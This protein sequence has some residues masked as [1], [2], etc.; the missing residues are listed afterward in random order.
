MA[1]GENLMLTAQIQI[2]GDYVDSFVYSGVL[3]LLDTQMKLTTYNWK[4]ILNLA[5][6]NHEY[7]D[8]IINIFERKK[9]NKKNKRP[10]EI[11]VVT[12]KELATLNSYSTDFDFWLTD[13][14]I[15]RNT[16]FVSGNEGVISQGAEWRRGNNKPEFEFKKTRNSVFSEPV[17]DM[18]IGVYSSL[19]PNVDFARL[20]VSCGDNGAYQIYTKGEKGNVHNPNDTYSLSSEHWIGCDLN[21]NV[22]LAVLKNFSH[23]QVFRF[24]E[25]IENEKSNEKDELICHSEEEISKILSDDIPK[26]TE[27]NADNLYG[28]Y[29]DNGEIKAVTKTKE[30]VNLSNLDNNEKSDNIDNC[31]IIDIVRTRFGFITETIDR[32]FV[33]YNNGQSENFQDFTNFRTFPKATTHNN[34]LHIVFDNYVSVFGF[35]IPNTRNKNHKNRPNFGR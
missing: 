18:S 21:T 32:L 35:D 10:Q 22:G 24:N 13:M 30:K 17:L 7:K 5:V 34:Q 33:E 16:I 31:E 14:D 12:K 28:F 26:P 8:N 3:F 2:E 6:K 4:D 27:F 29:V 25:R 1:T 20:L 19:V 11:L 9:I 15:F 23:R